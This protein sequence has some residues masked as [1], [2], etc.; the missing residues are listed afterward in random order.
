MLD[1]VVSHALT[2]DLVLHTLTEALPTVSSLAELIRNPEDSRWMA[3]SIWA[4]DWP[5][6][7]RELED[8]NGVL[9][10][11]LFMPVGHLMQESG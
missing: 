2:M 7:R 3:V 9:I 8:A 11:K 4:W 1:V 10:R 6:R 5:K